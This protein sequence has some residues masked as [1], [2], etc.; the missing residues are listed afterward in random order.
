MGGEPQ[1]R[2]RGDALSPDCN[3]LAV[4]VSR[5]SLNYPLFGGW[6]GWSQGVPSVRGMV[7]EIYL[8][9]LQTRVL[10]K[11]LSI[12]A[13]VRMADDTDFSI[14]PR[15]LPGNQLI[16]SMRGCPKDDQNCKDAKYYTAAA[17]GKVSE[18]AAWP[19]V[20]TQESAAYERCTSLL[21]YEERKTFV[22]IGPRNG[23][24]TPVLALD[25]QTLVPV[26][27]T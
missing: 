5:F 22:S 9:D 8:F 13:P 26:A 23:P 24:W 15:L 18:M 4:G 1:A 14:R 21:T 20:S 7:G 3:L 11:A 25:G 17:N 12:R 10:R 19:E 2:L 16:F 6:S 27:P